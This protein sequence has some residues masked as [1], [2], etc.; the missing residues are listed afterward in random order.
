MN[1]IE[2][3]DAKLLLLAVLRTAMRYEPLEGEENLTV[4]KR[5][6][7]WIYYFEWE[8]VLTTAWRA[9]AL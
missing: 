7:D 4:L 8:R 9:N 1:K 5:C 3:T 6:H 2:L